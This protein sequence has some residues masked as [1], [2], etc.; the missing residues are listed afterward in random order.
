MEELCWILV[1]FCGGVPDEQTLTEQALLRRVVL[2]SPQHDTVF[3]LLKFK[4]FIDK[5]AL[6]EASQDHRCL[7][8]LSF[9]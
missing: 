7:V 2:T 9:Q 4:D 5:P 6:T 8:P 3:A 1:W